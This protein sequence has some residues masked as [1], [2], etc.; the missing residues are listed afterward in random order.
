M[1]KDRNKRNKKNRV[2]QKTIHPRIY[3]LILSVLVVLIYA[4]TTNFEFVHIDDEKLI[5]GNNV[6]FDSSVP[7]SETFKQRLFKVHYKPLVIA[8]WKAEYNMFGA[9]PWHFHL[10]NWLLHLANT[11]I[12]FLI[13]TKL[14]ERIF[15][16]NKPKI[17]M[18]AFLLAMLFSINPLRLESVAWATERKDVLFSFFF[19]L[20]WL[21]YIFYLKNKNYPLVLLSSVLY[22]MS[23]LSKSMGITLI[24]VLFLTDF[25]YKRKFELKLVLEKIPHLLVFGLLLYLFGMLSS[26]LANSGL[27]ELTQATQEVSQQISSVAFIENMPKPVQLVLS[28]SLRFILWA[29]HSLIPLRLSV[30]Y[31][32]DAIFRFFGKSI[33]LFPFLVAGLFYILWKVRKKEFA[34]LWGLLFFGITL[35]PTLAVNTSGQAIFL[36]DRYTYI[37]SIGLFFI[38]VVLL[39][40]L[41]FKSLK[42][43]IVTTALFLFY[44]AVSMN[45]V[46]YWKNSETLFTQ[47]LK[48]YPESGL[49]HL[50][51]GR[52]YREQNNFEKA[53]EVYNQG[54]KRAPNYFRLYSNR[55]KIYFDQGKYDLAIADDSKCLSLN[56]KY[57][58][59]LTN[60]GAA[61]GM[62]KEFDKA[63]KDLTQA[64][65]MRPKH[66]G[67]LINRGLIY[68]Q[69]KQYE[70]TIED[71]N[72]Y[73][74]LKPNDPDVI[75]TLGLAYYRLKKYE[76]ALIEYN[77]SISIN[78]GVGAFYQNRSL[79][80]NAKGDKTKA[81][82]DV[83]KAQQLGTK[84]N[85]DY[86]SYLRKE[87]G[88]N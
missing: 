66:T 30:I 59:A 38:V 47:A 40:R 28:A 53:I 61:Y 1:R 74:Q 69:V 60:R 54:I 14:F 67:A 31:P 72:N 2:G 44:F 29:A 37:P 76:Q 83:L 77:R 10:F 80:Y 36:S 19:L 71:Y 46:N 34:Y 24:A 58:T 45:G 25:W 16:N 32:H 21:S 17:L 15:N 27:N 35:S 62:V 64:L 26:H 7:Y 8:S 11:I 65:E 56:P 3:I 13:G 23:G 42:Y 50:N 41:E 52:Y 48:I 87:I 51:L 4:K 86:I 82:K 88:D 70:K 49:S 20:S 57:L 73:L 12:L 22:L 39:S 55:G 79:L 63:I 68:F 81:L 84:V 78:P 18:S 5:F 85:P 6:V 75:N 43:N 33:F 9:S